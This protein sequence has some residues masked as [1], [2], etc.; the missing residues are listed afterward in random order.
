MIDISINEA[1]GTYIPFLPYALLVIGFIA[2]IKGADFFVDG[3]NNE[4]SL[5]KQL[6]HATDLAEKQN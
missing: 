6:L 4:E 2:L 5:R 3:S 1:L